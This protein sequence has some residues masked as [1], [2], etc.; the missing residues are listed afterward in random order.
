MGIL[1]YLDRPPIWQDSTG[2]PGILSIEILGVQ[3]DLP[4]EGIPSWL[5]I[6]WDTREVLRMHGTVCGSIGQVCQQQQQQ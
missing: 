5:W 2:Y 1:G 4:S 3:A 6:S